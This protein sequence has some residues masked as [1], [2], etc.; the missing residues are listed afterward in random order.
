ML[1]QK[2]L[3]VSRI[4]H[5]ADV[6]M[7]RWIMCKDTWQIGSTEDSQSGLTS[8]TVLP[9][10]LVK[11]ND[12]CFLVLGWIETCSY[13]TG[14]KLHQ[15]PFGRWSRLPQNFFLAVWSEP[16]L[17]P[18]FPHDLFFLELADFPLL[19]ALLVIVNNVSCVAASV[20]TGTAILQESPNFKPWHGLSA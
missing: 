16:A 5:Q 14:S 9:A 2:S 15:S 3:K 6:L 18:C 10:W 1:F 11:C 7:A 17:F 19:S 13:Y 20:S 4:T 12:T 8:N